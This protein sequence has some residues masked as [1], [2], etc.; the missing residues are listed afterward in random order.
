MDLVQATRELFESSSRAFPVRLWDGT[1]LPASSDAGPRGA[2]A[3]TSPRAL[4]ALLPPASEQRLAES[5]LDGDL[6]LDGDSIGLLEAAG[7]WEG[8]R[9]RASLATAL[10]SI[11][12]HRG[13]TREGA[14]ALVSRLS[15][16]PHSLTRDR[17]A[18]RHHYDFSD[19][20]YRLFLDRALVYSCA[21]FATGTESLEEAQEAKLD[22]ICRKLA[23]ARGERLLDVGCGW[24]SLLEH[25]AAHYQVDGLGITL[26][27]HQLAEAQRRLADAPAGCRV[28]VRAMDYRQVP[29]GEQFHKA[30]SVGMMEHVGRAHLDAYFSTV[31]RLLHPGGLFLNHAIADISPGIATL[32]WASRREGGFIDRYIFPDGDLVPLGLVIAAAERAGFE[33]RDVESLREHYAETLAAWLGR[34]EQRMDEA[35]ALVGRRAARVY[36]LYLA[37]SA[38]AFRLGRISVFQLLLAKRSENGRAHGVPRCRAAWYRP[39]ASPAAAQGTGRSSSAGPSAPASASSS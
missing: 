15:G 14:G 23:L 1:V 27:E 37:S 30:A 11:V 39:A 19:A 6:E 16:A 18:V 17:M 2:L 26:S 3:L 34:L 12:I 32:P 31:H 10:A 5:F 25:A 29:D 24:G 33:V 7:R 13:V 21:Y 38:A 28:M 20:F 22:L 4:D 8:P 36:R 9:L 35:V